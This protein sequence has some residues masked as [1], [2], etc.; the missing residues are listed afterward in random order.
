VSDVSRSISAE[1]RAHALR[2]VNRR[3]LEW[4]WEWAKSLL[5]AL[6][7]FVFVRAFFVEAFK[8]PPGAWSARCSS[9][10]SCS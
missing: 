4:V 3:G 2:R 1:Q 9:A 10:T 8:I 6:G 5:V 7:L